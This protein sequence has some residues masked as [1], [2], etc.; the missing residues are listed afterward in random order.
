MSVTDKINGH[1]VKKQ[2]GVD[3]PHYKCINCNIFT[4]DK[5]NFEEIECGE[6]P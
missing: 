3:S 2:S 6:E 1:K 4:D 5:E